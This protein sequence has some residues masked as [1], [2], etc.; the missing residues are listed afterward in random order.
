LPGDPGQRLRR[1]DRVLRDLH[2]FAAMRRGT[3]AFAFRG[4]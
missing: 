3:F 2:G 4:K 1:G